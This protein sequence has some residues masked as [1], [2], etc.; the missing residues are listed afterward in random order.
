MRLTL[1]RFPYMLLYKPVVGLPR[2]HE[3]SALFYFPAAGVAGF[4]NKATRSTTTMETNNY[5]FQRRP[6]KT[7][8]VNPSVPIP[9]VGISRKEVRHGR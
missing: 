8:K 3:E 5:A 1:V 6:E 2:G 4:N 9:T 7:V